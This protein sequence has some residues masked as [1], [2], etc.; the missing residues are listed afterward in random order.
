[1]IDIEAIKRFCDAREAQFVPLEWG[2][3]NTIRDAVEHIR[4]LLAEVERLSAKVGQLQAWIDEEYD[5]P[6]HRIPGFT[7]GA[8]DV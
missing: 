7:H 6:E 1:M 5:V 2:A 3:D 4:A 8:K